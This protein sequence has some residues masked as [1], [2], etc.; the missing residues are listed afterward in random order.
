[1]ASFAQEAADFA[2][3]LEPERLVHSLWRVEEIRNQYDPFAMGLHRALARLENHRASNAPHPEIGMG[4]DVVDPREDAPRPDANRPRRFAVQVCHVRPHPHRPRAFPPEA[5]QLFDDFVRMAEAG[6]GGHHDRPEVIR[7]GFLCSGA[8][9][10]LRI[11]DTF[12]QP[13]FRQSEV[14]GG[15][16]AESDELCLDPEC[17]FR[18]LEEEGMMRDRGAAECVRKVVDDFLRT[19]LRKCRDPTEIRLVDQ[20]KPIISVDHAPR[21]SHILGGLLSPDLEELD[22]GAEQLARVHGGAKGAD[23]MNLASPETGSTFGHLAEPLYTA[24]SSSGM[25]RETDTPQE[26]DSTKEEL[27][28]HVHDIT[29]ALGDKVSE[30]EIERELSSYLNVYRVSLDTAK[31]SI[32]KKHGGNPATLAVGVSKTIR[33]LGPGE[34][35]VNLLARIVAVYEKE[36]TPQGQETKTILSGI[37]GD[38]TATVPFTA[39][40][41]L[42]MPLAKGDVI[43]VP[44]AYTK[45]YRGQVQVHFGVRAPGRGRG[46]R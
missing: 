29:R 4:R 31:R 30:Q 45:E 16:E 8:H 36:V 32:V 1:M 35:S 34:Q 13:D 9:L 5:P 7:R 3:G 11:H 18:V 41:P 26:R 20:G 21:G 44:N 37:L 6:L 33:E 22:N 38:A 19:S 23:G 12:R 10:E 39:W 24:E 15:T 46:P 43:R 42:P 27:A 40:E 2:D 28:P 14:C 25:R 17:G